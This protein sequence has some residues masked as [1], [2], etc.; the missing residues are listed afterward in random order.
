MTGKSLLII[1]ALA[2]L[3]ACGLF[4]HTA[5]KV[6]ELPPHDETVPTV[7]APGDGSPTQADVDRVKNK[8]LGYTLDD[9]KEGKAL[10]ENN[11]ALCHDLV[12]PVNE[13][14]DDWRRIVPNMV[15]KANKKNGNTLDAAGEEKILRYVITM[16]PVRGK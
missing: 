7:E 4:K 1:G 12:D 8:F 6:E 3:T 9:L 2:V 13:P 16:G 5:P 11:C 15:V 10:Y 14:E